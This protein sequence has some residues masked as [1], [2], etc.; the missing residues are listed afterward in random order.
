MKKGKSM[1][2]VANSLSELIDYTKSIFPKGQYFQW[3]RGHLCETWDLMPSIYRGN[4]AKH[5]SHMSYDFYMRASIILEKKPQ[6]NDFAG[7]FSLM[8]NYGLPTRLLDWSKSLL[9]A[10]YFATYNYQTMP[11]VDGCI[12]ILR[13][14]RLN[15]LFGLG[16]I[17]PPLD[18]EVICS[19]LEPVFYPSRERDE[20]K[21]KIYAT[22]PVEANVRINAQ[23][24]AFTVHNSQTKLE[25]IVDD[26]LIEK[27]IIPYDKKPDILESIRLC[28]VSART[29]FPD[30]EHIAKHLKEY[31]EKEP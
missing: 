8:Q 26:K 9:I 20:S 23:H 14:G 12:W 21:Y 16:N 25:E 29:V 17:I 24:S 22:Y 30:L 19:L 2:Y 1:A 18:S 11:D 4:F 3:Y 13:P 6:K 28:G 31:Y 27:V 10:S 15:E 7:W 5:E